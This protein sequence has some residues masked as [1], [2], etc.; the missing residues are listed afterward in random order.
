MWGIC[1][2]LNDIVERTDLYIKRARRSKY[3]IDFGTRSIVEPYD[4]LLADWCCRCE[5]RG[6]ISQPM[7]QSVYRPIPDRIFQLSEPIVVH[8]FHLLVKAV[9]Y[10][11]SCICEM[12]F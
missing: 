2:C 6:I 12:G 8:I 5:G 11:T 9:P 3:S 4:H 10:D 1:D 7:G